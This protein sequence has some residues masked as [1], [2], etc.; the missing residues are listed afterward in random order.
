MGDAK[1]TPRQLSTIL[2][3][4]DQVTADVADVRGELIRS[5][6]KRAAA[7]ARPVPA[8]R[9]HRATRRTKR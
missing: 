9:S 7:A 8:L 5:M 2:G 6:A 1:L 4:L 3:K